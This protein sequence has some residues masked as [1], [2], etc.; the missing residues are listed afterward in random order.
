MPE[1]RSTGL[2]SQA[3]VDFCPLPPSLPGCQRSA[4]LTRVM[5]LRQVLGSWRAQARD[6]ELPSIGL[7]SH[8]CVPNTSRP[9]ARGWHRPFRFPSHPSLPPPTPLCHCLSASLSHGSFLPDP[10]VRVDSV[11]Q[12][13]G[14][15]ASADPPRVS[16]P[17][18][19]L[20]PAA[21]VCCFLSPYS[22]SSLILRPSSGSLTAHRFRY[23]MSLPL[24]PELFLSLILSVSLPPSLQ[25]SSPPPF[26]PPLLPSPLPSEPALP[27]SHPNADT[28]YS[29]ESQFSCRGTRRDWSGILQKVDLGAGSCKRK[30]S[31]PPPFFLGNDW[32]LSWE[33]DKKVP[34]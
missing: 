27:L 30:L 31:Q 9:S 3:P 1:L 11:L 23:N 34:E 5:G 10:F 21:S 19:S 22:V 14:L 33:A 4:G 18:S 6:E 13:F 8:S 12:A 29:S 25:S 7:M 20:T 15:T 26:S 32:L 2:P 17:V 16:A 28:K 24:S